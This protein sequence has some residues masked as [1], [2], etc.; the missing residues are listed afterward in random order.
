MVR[1]PDGSNS[2]EVLAQYLPDTSIEAVAPTM[3]HWN[4]LAQEAMSDM[5]CAIGEKAQARLEGFNNLR[6]KRADV[7]KHELV[8]W[9][10][11]CSDGGDRRR[12]FPCTYPTR[13]LRQSHTCLGS[14]TNILR[15]CDCVS[16]VPTATPPQSRL[17][18]RRQPGC[19]LLELA[20]DMGRAG[21]Y[22]IQTKILGLNLQTATWTYCSVMA[23]A[24]SLGLLCSQLSW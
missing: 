3:Q 22:D 24:G 19:P 1:C 12:R 9:I 23:I 20:V 11:V 6:Q 8:E 13:R 4:D 10:A 2:K 15:R 17:R 18:S 14:L 7:L 5:Q 16:G 21:P